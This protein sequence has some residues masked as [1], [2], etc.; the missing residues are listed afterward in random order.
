MKKTLLTL[1]LIATFTLFAAAQDGRGLPPVH[2]GHQPHAVGAPSV[3][4][5]C[6]GTSCFCPPKTCLY[7]AGDFNSNN[8]S[9][10]NGLFDFENPGIGL[11]D[12]EVWVGVKP[13]K[14]ATVVG[15]SGNYLTT[16]TN[17][18]INPTPFQVRVNIT[19]GQGGK[20]ACSTS[21]NATELCSVSM[22]GSPICSYYIKKLSKPCH[23]R[24]NTIYY[25][26]ESPQYDDGS[27]IGYLLDAEPPNKHHVGWPVDNDNSYFNSSSFGVSWEPTWGTNGECGGIG[28]DAFSISVSGTEKK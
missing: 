8:T 15:S 11:S 16:N 14:N 19:S 20:L 21:G 24:A 13:T 1:T 4:G 22:Q 5:E 26:W 18:G 7:Y 10:E 2:L 27:T 25:V 28:C 6:I 12:A 3:E 17:I 9:T 23:F